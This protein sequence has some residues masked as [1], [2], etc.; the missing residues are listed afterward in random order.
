MASA[1][2]GR[3][4]LSNGLQ[5]FNEQQTETVDDGWHQEATPD[6]IATTV[7]AEP[8]RSVITYNDSPDVG[9][10]RSINPYRGCEHGCIYCFARPSHAY[11]GLSPGLDF[12]TRLFYKRDAARLLER[13]LGSRSYVCKAITLGA[14]TDP[15][16]PVE[17]RLH[18]TRD[19][20]ETLLKW[21]HPVSII[22]KSTM[23]LRDLDLLT[24]FATLDLVNVMVSLTSMDPELKRLLEPRA[25]SGAARLATI[26]CLAAAGVP[27]GALIAPVIPVITDHELESLLEA[28]VA[29][30][31]GGAGYGLLRLPHELKD[32]FREW[33]EQH[34]P[35]KARHVLA[36]LTDLRNGKLNDSDF[37]TRMSGSG[38]YAELLRRRFELARRRL[39]LERRE[40]KPLATGH[41]RDPQAPGAQLGLDLTPR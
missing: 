35:G 13:E 40:A 24:Q 12:E 2:R 27:V 32:L 15:Y 41:F 11:L 26:R 7:T 34:H 17:R 4:A 38:T 1:F 22:T 30:G 21:R 28:A 9:F 20:L 23:I 8:A 16:Q 3:G 25:A 29:A 10:D 37:R 36:L 19:V 18:V 31:A 14:N 33:L 39:Q 6:S 5:R